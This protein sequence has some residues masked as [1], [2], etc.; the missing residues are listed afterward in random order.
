MMQ[1]PF[2]YL[3]QRFTSPKPPLKTS[4]VK[5][6]SSNI[7]LHP[8]QAVSGAGYRSDL[9]IYLLCAL[10]TSDKETA[11]GRGASHITHLKAQWLKSSTM[12]STRNTVLAANV[13]CAAVSWK[14]LIVGCPGAYTST[15]LT[16][17][18]SGFELHS[19]TCSNSQDT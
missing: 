4:H 2:I 6:C 12:P 19:V 3:T 15:Q 8:S 13:A 9:S 17:A 14:E 10:G 11:R 16:P 5:P 1:L 7:S 18:G